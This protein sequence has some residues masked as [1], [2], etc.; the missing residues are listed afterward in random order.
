LNGQVVAAHALDVLVMVFMP[1]EL[2]RLVLPALFG[3]SDLA[4]HLMAAEDSQEAAMDGK[5]AV[6]FGAIDAL[7]RAWS[8][9]QELSSSA[10]EKITIHFRQ[11]TENGGARVAEAGAAA[12]GRVAVSC[13]SRQTLFTVLDALCYLGFLAERFQVPNVQVELARTLMAIASQEAIRRESDACTKV[14]RL[15][16]AL[17]QRPPLCEVYHFQKWPVGRDPPDG[18][19]VSAPSEAEAHLPDVKLILQKADVL[20]LGEGCV[21]QGDRALGESADGPPSFKEFCVPQSSEH[22]CSHALLCIVRPPLRADISV[23]L[24][25]TIAQLPSSRTQR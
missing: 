12:L 16:F 24:Q 15:A 3:L 18:W 19:R 13:V 20:L 25:T 11:I 9:M 21:I 5:A 2:E 10:V 1:A 7:G 23:A 14:R 4:A 6:I 8:R 22:R 17:F